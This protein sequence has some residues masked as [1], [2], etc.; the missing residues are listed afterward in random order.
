MPKDFPLVCH[1]A[2]SVDESLKENYLS[3]GGK[4]TKAQGIDLKS[5]HKLAT[6]TPICKINVDTDLRLVFTGT[7]RHSFNDSPEVFDPRT[8]LKTVIKNLEE[9]IIFTSTKVFK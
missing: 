7:L 4:L 8:H 5:L 9:R 2:S 3:S 1:G 6:T